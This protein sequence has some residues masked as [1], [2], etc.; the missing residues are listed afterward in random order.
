NIKLENEDGAIIL[1]ATDSSSSNAGDFVNLEDF[2]SSRRGAS[3][4]LETHNV[5]PSRGH[6]PLS[7]FSINSSNKVTAGIVQSAEV[8]VRSTGEVA[9]EDATLGTG[10]TDDTATSNTYYLLDETNGNNMDLE[11]GT[12]ITH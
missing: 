5:F 12:G 3:L 11:G 4:L 1:D 2:H 10:A 6:I 9:L 7:N 8:V